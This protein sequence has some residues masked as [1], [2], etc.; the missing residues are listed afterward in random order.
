[1]A[2]QNL[3]EKYRLN[4]RQYMFVK[5]YVVD[6]NGTRAAKAAGYSKRT[7]ES[8]ASSLL[9]NPKV[10]KAIQAEIEKKAKRTEIT[11]DRVLKEL[12]KI[13]FSDISDIYEEVEL[14]D[15]ET[16]ERVKAL[17]MKPLSQIDGALIK[18]IVTEGK[19]VKS[20]RL[21]SKERAL[22]KLGQHLGLFDNALNEKVPVEVIFN[23]PRPPKTERKEE[24]E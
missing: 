14:I 19:Q 21:W 17:K 20:I 18:E 4:D 11:A 5:E 16:Q 23:I 12:A 9:R 22:E 1:M 3:K 24:N 10:Q 7:A 2:K 15:P 6:F 8:M 13:A